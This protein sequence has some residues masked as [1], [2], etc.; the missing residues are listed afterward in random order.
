MGALFGLVFLIVPV[1]E[2]LLFI[3]IQE[4][5]GLGP[6]LLGVIVTAIIGA[7]LVRRQGLSVWRQFQM[8]LG[9]GGMPARQLAHGAMVLFGGALLLTPGYLT[10]AVGFVLMV[11][12]VREAIRRI[13]VR[14]V[15]ARTVIIR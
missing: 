9:S 6:T 12:A 2:L 5:I 13:G 3:W 8:E 4:R 10:D 14:V 11:P 7:A 1:I 15:K